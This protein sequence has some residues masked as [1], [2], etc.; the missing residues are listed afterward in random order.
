NGDQYKAYTAPPTLLMLKSKPQRIW[1]QVDYDRGEV[2]FFSSTDMKSDELLSGTELLVGFTQFDLTVLKIF[3]LRLFLWT[4]DTISFTKLLF[5]AT[6]CTFTFFSSSLMSWSDM[7]LVGRAFSLVRK[8]AVL[9]SHPHD[10]LKLL[11]LKR[12]LPSTGDR[13]LQEVDQF[14]YMDPEPLVTDA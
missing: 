4:R 7:L 12:L 1:V 3:S 5:L 10:I 6:T 13:V 8:A 14:S 2:S 9:V 11:Q